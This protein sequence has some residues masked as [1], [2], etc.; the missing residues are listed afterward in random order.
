MPAGWAAAAATVA[1]AVISSQSN[2]SA[3]NTSAEAQRYAA[4]QAAAAA[5]FKPVGIT[6]RFGRSTFGYGGQPQVVAA[7]PPAGYSF[8]APQG[9]A[10]AMDMPPEGQQ[11]AYNQ[12]TGERI[13]VPATTLTESPYGPQELSSAGYQLSPDLKA[14]QDRIMATAGAWNPQQY[15][16]M[17]QKLFTLGQGYLSTS[18]EAAAADY[19][20]KQRQL[21]APSREQDLA[22]ITNQQFQAGRSGLGVGGTKAGYTVGG[23]GLMQTNPQLA[24]YYNS[25]AGQDASLAANADQYARDRM[26]YGINLMSSAAPSLFNAGYGPLQTALGLSSTIE[27][28]G[29][30]PFTMSSELGGRSSTAGANAGQS[31]LAGGMAAARTQQL[32]NQYSVPGA[33]LTGAGTNQNL[34]NWFDKKINGSGLSYN[35]GAGYGTATGYSSWDMSNPELVQTQQTYGV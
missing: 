35:P 21:M 27:G 24:A 20:A 11:W 14:I 6:T 15:Q 10:Y 18:P 34:Y 33:L 19:Y 16:D 29:Q 31:L 23:P 28:L 1:G 30:Q 7:Q 22:N 4:D 25:I 13:A 5:R 26:N 2:K 32:A 17:S 9:I 3:A 8:T 12:Q